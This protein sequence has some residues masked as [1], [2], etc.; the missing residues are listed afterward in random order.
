MNFYKEIDKRINKINYEVKILMIDNDP[1][2][3]E[4][5]DIFKDNHKI[6]LFKYESIKK[7]YEK[8]LYDKK[9]FYKKIRNGK[10][11]IESIESTFEKY[12]DL[13]SSLILLKK[14]FFNGVIGGLSY[15]SADFIRAALKVIGLDDNVERI[16]SIMFLVKENSTLFFSDPSVNI[17]IDEKT[18]YNIGKNH[19]NF[20]EKLN[21]ESNVAFLSYSTYGSVENTQTQEIRNISNTLQKN[22]KRRKIIGEV[23]F[24]AAFDKKIRARKIKDTNF[25]KCEFTS[26]IFPDLNSANIGYKLAQ[27]LANYDAFGPILLGL[28][29]PANDLSR[30]ASKKD[31]IYTIYITALQIGGKNE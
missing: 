19:I 11:N 3:D 8:D 2:I 5:I 20:L 21:V 26:F 12:D 4:V 7:D 13:Y 29:Q 18:L 16:S 31:I 6:K 10:E 9:E 23:Q 25:N 30:G 14:G 27:Y 22:T 28:N 17:N 1:L 15:T 24:D